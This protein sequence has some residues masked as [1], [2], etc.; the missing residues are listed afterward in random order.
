MSLLGGNAE[1]R[2][3]RLPGYLKLSSLAFEV[4]LCP[5]LTSGDVLLESEL[6]EQPSALS[7]FEN[8]VQ[9]TKLLA[10]TTSHCSP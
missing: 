2:F 9:Q 3:L 1:S 4:S 5:I 7:C 10:K 6:I 8:F